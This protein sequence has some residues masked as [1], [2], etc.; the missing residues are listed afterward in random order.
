MKKKILI[1]DDNPDNVELLRKRLSTKDMTPRPP[2][3]GKR[4]SR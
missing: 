4:P 1:A 3:M 2:L